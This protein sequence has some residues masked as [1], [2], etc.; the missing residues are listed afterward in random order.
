MA[1]ENPRPVPD[2][3]TVRAL[4]AA[5]AD[6]WLDEGP[7]E[8][9]YRFRSTEDYHPVPDQPSIDWAL[10]LVREAGYKVVLTV[11]PDAAEAALFDLSDPGLRGRVAHSHPNAMQVAA[12]AAE[13][14]LAALAPRPEPRILGFADHGDNPA[15]GDDGF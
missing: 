8:W 1:T 11:G 4:R 14:I 13:A 5:G 6:L 9:Y 10:W 7:G 12:T 3:L 2:P 15:R